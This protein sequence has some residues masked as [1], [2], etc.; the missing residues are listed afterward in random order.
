M[1]FYFPL[2]KG[3]QSKI[4][5]DCEK[6]GA[7]YLNEKNKN[8]KMEP[9][10]G[11]NYNGLVIVG[12]KPSKDDDKYNKHMVNE[13]M[14]IMR[15]QFL[16]KGIRIDTD[17]VLTFALRCNSTKATDTQYRCC[18]RF[19]DATL[20]ELKPKLIVTFGEMAFK[21]VMGL[22]KKVG[23]TKIRGRVIPNYEYNSMVAPM[24]DPSLITSYNYRD[25]LQNDINKICK[26]WHKR[27][28]LRNYVNKLIKKRKILENI[29]IH[30]VKA[31][32]VDDIFNIIHQLKEVSLD[33]ET[34]N[35]NPFDSFFEITHISFGISKIGYVFHEN[36]W[37][38]NIDMWKK[39]KAH[40]QSILTNPN[41]LK[42]IQNAKFEDLCSRYV[43]GIKEIVNT[44]CTMLATHV[45]DERR[46]CTSL[47]F[48]NLIRF[49]MPPYNETINSFL[50][51]KHK[52]DKC[53]RIR[54]APHDDMILYAA[55]DVIT[56]FNN[57]LLLS[58]EIIPNEYS[59]A[60]AN[61]EFLHR[62]H[63]AFANMTKRGIPI[64]EEIFSNL[65]NEIEQKINQTLTDIGNLKS[66][67]EYNL[68][69]AEKNNAKSR[70]RSG[71]AEFKELIEQ[72]KKY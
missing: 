61:Y 13:R 63:W 60:Q 4:T 29:K 37:L 41:I 5:Y 67:Q 18:H 27:Y 9:S 49:G 42:V 21:S 36:L 38:D 22:K 65:Y 48:Q 52:N 26:L 43:F 7:Y 16:R 20:K 12:G 68:F 59:N 70:S 3:K 1:T 71:E 19:L 44:Y 17:A 34:T 23:A 51:F 72:T 39:I 6:C 47:D 53:N 33:Y 8:P 10:I 32:E 54:Q 2:P 50:K 28:R 46:G 30:E 35:L 40:M 11:R 57:Y 15:T 62:G 58:N 56:T 31:N 55:L 24:F 45:V 25:A 66:F 69:L 14:K 64:G